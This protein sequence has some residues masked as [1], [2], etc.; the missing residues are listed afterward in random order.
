M[1]SQTQKQSMA[2]REARRREDRHSRTA[3]P[4]RLVTV[5]GTFC[6]CL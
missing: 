3:A 6:L 1:D 4:S 2:Q 5:C